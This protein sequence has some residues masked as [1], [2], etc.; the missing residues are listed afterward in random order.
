[1]GGT[2]ANVAVEG[3]SKRLRELALNLNFLEIFDALSRRLNLR[4]T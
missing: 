1:M 4:D 2:P 3:D